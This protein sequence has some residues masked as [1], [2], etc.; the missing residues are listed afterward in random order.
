[1]SDCVDTIGCM[2][3]YSADSGLNT[4]S[5]ACLREYGHNPDAVISAVL[6]GKLPPGLQQQDWSAE[7]GQGGQGGEEGE[8]AHKPQTEATVQEEGVWSVGMASN[9][10]GLSL[11]EQ[12]SSVFDGDEFDVFRRDRVE[13]TKIQKGK[14]FARV[15]YARE[16]VCL[17]FFKIAQTL[18]SPKLF[19]TDI[20]HSQ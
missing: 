5:Q 7:G 11:L 9:G 12:R 15:T 1:M 2:Y 3:V 13:H 17:W 10:A 18:T 4:S 6:E 8:A 19:R 14:R 20:Y 16:Y